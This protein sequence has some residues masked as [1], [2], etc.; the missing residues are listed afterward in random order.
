MFEMSITHLIGNVKFSVGHTHTHT[1]THIYI[2]V[3]MYMLLVFKRGDQTGD[4]NLKI[5][6]F[7][8]YICKIMRLEEIIQKWAYIKKR[9]LWKVN[10][11][12]IYH[13]FNYLKSYIFSSVTQSC[14]TLTKHG[15]LEKRMASRFCFLPWE[16]HKQYEK[17]K[18]HWKMNPPGREVP[19]ML[20]EKSGE[21]TPERMKRWSQ[22]KQCPVVDVAGNGSKEQYW[23]GTWNVGSMN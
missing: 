12:Y 9:R 17:A 21:I 16:P 6:S 11:S 4:I 10:E 1:H 14:L 13:T 5:N 22:S 23:T 7:Y 3:Y 19:S 8:N 18:R 15:P 2:Y 20:L